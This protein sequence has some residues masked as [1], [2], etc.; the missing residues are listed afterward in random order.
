V[1]PAARITPG[2]L[3]AVWVVLR[4]LEKLGDSVPANQLLPFARRSGLRCGGLP[5][6]DGFALALDGGFVVSHDVVR[7]TDLGREALSHCNEEEPTQEVLRLFVSVYLLRQPPTWVAY[8]Q[9]D[10]RSLDIVLPDSARELLRDAD[11]LH[12]SSINE[13]EDLEAWAWWDALR[14]VPIVEETAGHRK[15]IGDAAERLSF[16]YEKDRLQTEG[17]PDL[18]ERVRWV[19]RESPAY[20]FDILSYSGR[21][22]DPTV[23]T[24]PIGIEV[25]GMALVAQADFRFYLTAH[26]SETG[27][28][29]GSQYLFHLWDGVHPGAERPSF[30]AQP[31]LCRPPL[32]TEHLPS[33]PTCRRGCAWES[34]LLILPLTS[35]TLPPSG[36][37]VSRH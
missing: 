7:L 22:L 30:R 8:W 4:S 31:L 20:G 11:L 28:R 1:K 18:A 32:L 21:S 26:E 25:K 23:P 14:G 35:C 9:G 5:I 27:L 16:E 24:R 33:P 3:T 36:A 15:S 29:L 2:R 19:A 12:A 17:F 37:V 13:L 6:E 10:P 34:A